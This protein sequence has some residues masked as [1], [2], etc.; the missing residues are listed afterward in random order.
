MAMITSPANQHIAL[1]RSL[2]TAKGRETEG[3]FLI[4]GP[5]LLVA[6]LDARITPRLLVY[7]PLAL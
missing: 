4:E 6:A 7:D 1:L 5:H 3:L 2:Q